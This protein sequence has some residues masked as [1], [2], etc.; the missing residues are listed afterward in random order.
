MH[1]FDRRISRSTTT[2]SHLSVHESVMQQHNMT[3]QL[4]LTFS[5]LTKGSRSCLSNQGFSL[6]KTKG[7]VENFLATIINANEEMLFLQTGEDMF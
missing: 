1:T 6:F 4:E 7:E 3:S 5:T 2:S